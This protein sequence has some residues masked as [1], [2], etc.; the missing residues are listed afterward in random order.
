MKLLRFEYLVEM[1]VILM[2]WPMRH[3]QLAE[4]LARYAG[5]LVMHPRYR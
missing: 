2:G 5:S 4:W 1:L 3:Y